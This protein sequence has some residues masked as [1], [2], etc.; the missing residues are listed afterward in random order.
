[1]GVLQVARYYFLNFVKF[2]KIF[3]LTFLRLHFS[4]FICFNFD[5]VEEDKF[6]KNTINQNNLEGINLLFF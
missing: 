4:N 5:Q 1:M 3:F 6:D 2:L